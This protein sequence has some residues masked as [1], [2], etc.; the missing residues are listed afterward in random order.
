MPVWPRSIQRPKRGPPPIE[1]AGYTDAPERMQAQDRG[2][3]ARI[4]RK[5]GWDAR[6]PNNFYKTAIASIS[7]SHSGAASEVTPTIVLGGVCAPKYSRRTAAQ[8]GR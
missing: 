2:R 7:M 3:F 1:G 4:Y 6:A 5:S 8:S